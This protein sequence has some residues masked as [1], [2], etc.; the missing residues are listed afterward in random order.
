MEELRHQG[1][2][3]WAMILCSFSLGMN[4]FADFFGVMLF[5]VYFCGKVEI[6]GI[7]RII[8]LTIP[9][10]VV[11]FLGVIIP[12]KEMREYEEKQSQRVLQSEKLH[13]TELEKLK[14]ELAKNK[15][16]EDEIIKGDTIS[17]EKAKHN[18]LTERLLPFAV[19][20]ANKYNYHKACSDIFDMSEGRMIVD[21]PQDKCIYIN[22]GKY[23][24]MDSGSMYMYLNCIERAMKAGDEYYKDLFTELS[25]YNKRYEK[26]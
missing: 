10:V 21:L 17:Y 8:F 23:V 22:D 13:K 9:F 25:E 24:K 5:Y 15:E 14:V 18:I 4:F 1:L 16:L 11:F 7:K 20:M 3:A 26:K 2:W 6:M 12:S 19:I